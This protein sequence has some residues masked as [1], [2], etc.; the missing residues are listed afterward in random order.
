V[1]DILHNAWTKPSQPSASESDVQSAADLIV[2]RE[3]SLAKSEGRLPNYDSPVIQDELFGFLEAGHDTTSTTIEWGLKYLADNQ[4]A[5]TKL[6]KSL[7]EA[8][9]TSV[10]SNETPSGTDIARES[11]PYL[12]AVVQEVLRLAGTAGTNVRIATVDTEVLGYFIPK[13]TDV[14]LMVCAFAHLTVPSP[15]EMPSLT[16]SRTMAPA[17]LVHR[18]SAT[19]TKWSNVSRGMGSGLMRA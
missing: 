2:S 13:G 7:Q 9:P 14:F 3:V 8:F 12:D 10:S 17:T 4:V 19:E 11:I 18:L 15:A 6:R 16:V 1:K 5:Q